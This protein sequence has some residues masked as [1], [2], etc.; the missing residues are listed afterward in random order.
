MKPDE[1]N[2]SVLDKEDLAIMCGVKKFHC[3]LHGRSFI[4][5]SDHKPLEKLLHEK[6]KLSH[7]A[8]PH[9]KRWPL[10]FD[11]SAYEFAEFCKHNH[12]KHITVSPHHPASNGLAEGA[13]QILKKGIKNFL[14]T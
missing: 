1:K 12:I 10:D 7:M 2:Y 4:I 14:G 13:V 9:I 11:L 5:Q 8:A 3:Y 6:N